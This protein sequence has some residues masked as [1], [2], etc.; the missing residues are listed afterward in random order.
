MR[1]H[2]DSLIERLDRS[3]PVITPTSTF[4]DLFAS[5]TCPCGFRQTISLIGQ[6]ENNGQRVTHAWSL[7]QPYHLSTTL[8]ILQLH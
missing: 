1:S 4:N 7:S 3:T 6:P 8:R 5:T 2:L